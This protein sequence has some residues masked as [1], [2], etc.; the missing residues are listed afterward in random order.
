MKRCSACGRE[1]PLADFHA[2]RASRDGKT[3]QCRGCIRDRDAARYAA[4]REINPPRPRLTPE[5]LRAN[6]RAQQRSWERRNRERHN[7]KVN[8]RRREALLFVLAYKETHPCERCGESHPACLQFHH[9]SHAVKERDVSVL[10]HGGA[11]LSRLVDEIAKCEVLCANCHFK[12]HWPASAMAV[13]GADPDCC[14]RCC[15]IHP[16][17][18]DCPSVD[19]GLRSKEG[20]PRRDSNSKPP[21]PKSDA[22]S[23]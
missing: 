19:H 15:S 21:D 6:L 18:A 1:L 2:R 14:S 4:W 8:R 5:Q 11:A 22:L 23:S 13:L 10:A 20:Y 3:P 16:A 17:G 7:A 12:E 9:P